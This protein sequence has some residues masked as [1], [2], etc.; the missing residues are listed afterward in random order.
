MNQSSNSLQILIA[1]VKKYGVALIRARLA[2]VIVSGILGGVITVGTQAYIGFWE[3]REKNQNIVRQKYVEILDAQREF[4]ARLDR[5]N[6]V[7][8]GVKDVE[9]SEGEFSQLAYPYIS[10]LLAFSSL[11]PGTEEAARYYISAI[12]R[13]D[14]YYSTATPPAIESVD[15]VIFYGEFRQDFDMYNKSRKLYMSAVE[16]EANDYIGYLLNWDS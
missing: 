6:K 15:G 7:F 1:L 4:E 8:E 5:Y 11:L 13:L 10:Q 3:F 2:L 16:R 12:T 9:A 14:R